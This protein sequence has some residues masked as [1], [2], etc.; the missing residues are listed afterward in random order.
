MYAED[1]DGVVPSGCGG[2][3][4]NCYFEVPSTLR[5][6][7]EFGVVFEYFRSSNRACLIDIADR[8]LLTVDMHGFHQNWQKSQV[9]S[10]V[11]HNL[12]PLLQRASAGAPSPELSIEREG[13]LTCKL[14]GDLRL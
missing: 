2:R 11:W 13:A 9:T 10:T 7:A 1:T 6:R 12:S 4:N 8:S 3:W 14:Q 5:V